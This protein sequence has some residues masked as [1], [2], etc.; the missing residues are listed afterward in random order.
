ME[1]ATSGYEPWRDYPVKG[2][3]LDNLWSEHKLTHAV[4]LE[5]AL[6]A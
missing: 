2:W 5:Y 3:W 4:Y 6:V 1:V